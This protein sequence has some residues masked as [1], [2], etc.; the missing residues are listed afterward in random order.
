[1]NC[2]RCRCCGAFIQCCCRNGRN[3]QNGINGMTPIIGDN[4]NW[5]LGNTD[6][7]VPA[8]GQDGKIPYIGDN[9]NWWIN[10]VDTS[11][12]AEGKNGIDGKDGTSVTILGSYD[13]IEELIA[14]HPTGELGDGYLI[15]GDLYVWNGT[16]WENVGNIQ[17]SAGQNG[18]DGITPHIGDN[19]NWFIGDFDTGILARGT[20]GMTP[21]VYHTNLST[22]GSSYDIVIKNVV[23]HLQASAGTIALSLRSTGSSILADVKRSSQYDAT[24]IEGSSL[25]GV[26]LTTTNQS[27]DSIIYDNSNEMH[28]TWIRQR[29]P[30]TN[31]WSLYEV[32]LFPSDNGARTDIWVYKIYE[33]ASY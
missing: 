21:T 20:N 10:G 3:G 33:N 32:D 5:W 13:T 24:G 6:T 29:D 30:I 9:G 15:N 19:D 1:M 25:N 17:G 4:G 7:E 22:S 27:L 12:V 31:L 23:Y 11:V 26:T 8:R 18:N 16:S 28:R 2:C 14:E